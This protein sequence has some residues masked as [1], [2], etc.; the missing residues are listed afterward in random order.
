MAQRL[1][2]QFRIIRNKIPHRSCLAFFPYTIQV[3]YKGVWFY[4]DWEY[5]GGAYTEKQAHDYIRHQKEEALKPS[6]VYTE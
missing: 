6:I 5:A 1:F 3:R 2:M 4:G